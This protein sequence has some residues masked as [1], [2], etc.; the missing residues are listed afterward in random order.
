MAT[1]DTPKAKSKRG[2]ASMSAEQ[3]SRIA[4]MGGRAS[5]ASGGAHKWTKEEASAAGKKG[6]LN[7][8]AKAPRPMVKALG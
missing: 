3:K 4:S 8:P 5:H 2:F 1:P 7:R 6:H